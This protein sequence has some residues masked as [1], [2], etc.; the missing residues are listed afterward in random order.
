[1]TGLSDGTSFVGGFC[2]GAYCGERAGAGE[3]AIQVGPSSGQ[4]IK[5]NTSMC[6]TGEIEGHGLSLTHTLRRAK[7]PHLKSYRGLRDLGK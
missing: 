2:W 3:E 6:D 1:M 7:S 4:S 5:R